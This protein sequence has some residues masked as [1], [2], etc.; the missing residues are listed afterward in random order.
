[1]FL[2]K[3]HFLIINPTAA[4]GRVPI[5]VM[6]LTLH[7]HVLMKGIKSFVQYQVME[8]LMR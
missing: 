1:M 5:L 7:E 3:E 6:Q 4:G 2:M 8:Q